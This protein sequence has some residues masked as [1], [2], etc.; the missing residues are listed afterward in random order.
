MYFTYNRQLNSYKINSN[1]N[2]IYK[3][4]KKILRKYKYYKHEGKM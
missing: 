2:N 3:T 4:G 1:C